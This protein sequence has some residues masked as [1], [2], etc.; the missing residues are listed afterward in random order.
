MH[1]LQLEMNS[2]SGILRFLSKLPPDMDI[3]QLMSVIAATR[4]TKAQYEEIS[5][6]R[7]QTAA[8]RT[9]ASPALTRD[10][11]APPLCLLDGIASCFALDG[12]GSQPLSGA[13]SKH[14]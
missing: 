1:Q 12:F 6:S 4:L 7:R 8:H 5:S 9:P 11:D 3:D 14:K 10:E 2:T 13:V